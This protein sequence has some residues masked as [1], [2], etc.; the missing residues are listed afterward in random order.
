MND[1]ANKVNDIYKE[2]GYFDKYGGSIV[3]TL[4]IL[5]IFFII[6]SYF[7]VISKIEPIKKDWNNQK[8]NPTVIPF[9]GLIN[10]PPNMSGIDFTGKNFNGCINNILASIA[11]IFIKPINNLGS[12]IQQNVNNIVNSANQIRKKISSI[13]SNFAS[14]D[15]DIMGRIMNILMPLRYMLIKFKDTLGKVHGTLTASLYTILGT[16]L[17]LKSFLASTVNFLVASLSVFAGIILALILSFF[18]IP[19][20]IPLLI[21]FTTV[22]VPT[23]LLITNLKDIISLTEKSVPKKPSL[24]S[25]F[26]ENTQIRMINGTYKNIKDV[27]P[28]EILYG[29]SLITSKMKLSTQGVTMYNYRNTIVSG[30]HSVYVNGK[31]TKIKDIPEAQVIDDYDKPFIYCINTDNKVI[32]INDE[33]YCDWDEI[34]DGNLYILYKRLGSKFTPIFNRKDIHKYLDGGFTKDTMITME[35]GSKKPIQ[36]V[37]I[38]DKIYG[39]ARVYGTVEITTNNMNVYSTELQGIKVVGAPNLQV[40]N[41]NLGHFSH[42]QPKSTI[43]SID[44]RPTKLYHLL[45]EDKRIVVDGCSFYDYNGSIDVILKIHP[46]TKEYKQIINNRVPDYI[47]SPQFNNNH[48]IMRPNNKKPSLWSRLFN[49]NERRRNKYMKNSNKI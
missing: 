35:N 18:G 29:N 20:A 44:K 38:E 36:D 49:K 19:A 1:F 2:Y 43:L 10:K 12:V 45:T 22:A 21:T 32:N 15:K 4:F 14:I 39:G 3:I 23:I 26:D 48:Y 11:G 30:T 42:L 33:V 28:N 41:E 47:S 17:G 6:L 37:N 25:C 31:L 8:C 13:S 24:S 5:F 40:Y 27:Y 9:A 7:S 34:N 16:Y 46:T